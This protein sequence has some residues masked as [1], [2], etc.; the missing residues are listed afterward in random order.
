[1]MITIDPERLSQVRKLRGLTQAAL[2]KKARVDKQTV[3][4]LEH[5]K[6]PRR[7]AILERVTK[8]MD[9]EIGV[10]TG[11]RAMPTDLVAV[12]MR[13]EEAAYQLNVRVN[14]AVRN[15]YELAARRY[16]VSVQKIAQLAPLLFVIIAE[17]SLQN[18]DK[19]VQEC[20]TK[21]DE[22]CVRASKIP[23]LIPI[24]ELASGIEEEQD[25]IRR[26]DIFG[27]HLTNS[28]GYP[29]EDYLQALAARYGE[30]TVAS[31]SPNA[32]DYRVC[33]SEA[34]ALAGEEFADRLLS[35]EVPIHRMPRSLDVDKRAEW[36]RDPANRISVQ[37]IEE[38]G[39]NQSIDPVEVLALSIEL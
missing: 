28:S 12:P 35:G 21:Y 26:N 1:M 4:R 32:T 3:Y 18:R 19:N 11:E 31:V 37:E 27:R 9:I 10:L 14:P 34:I 15:A 5:E 20:R 7:L 29:F 38:E 30:I 22:Y 23:S 13:S 8:A 25:S 16:G 17:A 6:K 2:A 24:Y 33:R 36:I 39:S